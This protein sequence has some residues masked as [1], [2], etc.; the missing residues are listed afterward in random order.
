MPQFW[1]H[2]ENGSG[3]GA[4]ELLRDHLK[5][6][7]NRAAHAASAF[8]ARD[9][10]RLAGLLHD[11]GKYADQFQNRL[12][13]PS[14]FP[15]RDHWTAGAAA[16][17]LI[18]RSKTQYVG[19]NTGVALAIL[20]HHV[21]LRA[22]PPSADELAR[23]LA[24]EIGKPDLV[25]D[26]DVSRLLDRW[27]KDGFHIGDL[28]RGRK[29]SRDSA[30]AMLD[31]RMLFSAL[32][33]ADFLETEAHFNG[34]TT[35]PRCPRPEGPPLG[36]RNACQRVAGFVAEKQR[37][38]NKPDAVQ[39]IRTTLWD[40]CQAAATQPTGLFTLTAPT[41]AGKTL[42]M[43]GFALRHAIQHPHL[44][45]V[46]VVLPFLNIIEQTAREYENLFGTR[47]DFPNHFVL[48][49]HSLADSDESVV[50]AQSPKHEQPSQDTVDESTR[51]RR[52]LAENWDSPI[53]LTTH[54]KCLESL[55]AHRPARCRKLHRLAGSV[56]LFDEVQTLP[57]KLAVP[58]LATLSRLADPDGPYRS[59]VVFATATQPAFEHLDQPVRKLNPVGW[60]P[61]SVVPEHNLTS[62]F[63]AASRRV[64]VEWRDQETVRIE[65]LADELAANDHGQLLCIVNLKRHAAD[66]TEALRKR[67]GDKAAGTVFHLSTSLCPAHRRKV[68]DAVN[69]RLRPKNNLPCRLIA[70]QCVEAGVDLDFP[71]VYR[72]FAPLDAIAQA[73]GRC[74]RHGARPECGRVIVINLDDGAGRTQFPPGYAEAVDITRLHLNE[75][76]VQHGSLG[77]LDVINSPNLL[78]QYFRLLYDLTGRGGG[79]RDDEQKLWDAIRGG[80]FEDVAKEYRIIDTSTINVLVPY[81]RETFESLIGEMDND[82]PRNP[83]M[84]RRWIQRARPHAVGVY[85]PTTTNP[86]SQIWAHLQP[87][88]FSRRQPVD[89]HDAT[90]FHALP[91]ADYDAT[92]GLKL[93][94][95]NWWVV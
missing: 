36:A 89:T 11:L 31:V 41:G 87:I 72:A 1:G 32:V 3:T 5:H 2:S 82:R 27:Q 6:V 78:Q 43:L 93:P 85:R 91:G 66:L 16:A 59:T 65:P 74:N 17:L 55:M 39:R 53:I 57:P 34:N 8:G 44:R 45:R 12:R 52:L 25:T 20:G 22:L 37:L 71:V 79:T 47:T 62:M 33:D 70:T 13:N 9:E 77:N 46:I 10:A 48:E 50:T 75:L 7:A 51:L 94:E 15:G 23:D 68:L 58:T 14:A 90:W 42:A 69:E 86:N 29:L 54:V 83:D 60:Q 84:I 56:I 40:Q 21:G 26:S 35:Q 61:R 92:L 19:R 63:D 18:D 30:V 88:Q 95:E 81:N 24:D 64:R 76:R 38:A 67:L 73:A 49:D 80:N 28:C 4:K